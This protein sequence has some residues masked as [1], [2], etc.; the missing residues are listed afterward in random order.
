[1]PSNGKDSTTVVVVAHAVHHF[2]YRYRNIL[3]CFCH[4]NDIIRKKCSLSEVKAL[5]TVSSDF[6]WMQMFVLEVEVIVTV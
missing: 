5:D 6:N 2:W 4:F 3:R 1:M